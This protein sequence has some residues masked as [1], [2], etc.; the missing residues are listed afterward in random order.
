MATSQRW[1]KNLPNSDLALT[2]IMP[3]VG[4]AH[5]LIVYTKSCTLLRPANLGTDLRET[6][7]AQIAKL[8]AVNKENMETQSGM[9]GAHSELAIKPSTVLCPV[10][11]LVGR[12]VPCTAKTFGC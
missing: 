10:L 7:L 12:P 3:I 6:V 5:Q 9:G 2:I 1:N 8:K 4:K 11:H